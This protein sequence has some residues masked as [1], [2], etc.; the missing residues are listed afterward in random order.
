MFLDRESRYIWPDGPSV[1]NWLHDMWG[2]QEGVNDDNDDITAGV[3]TWS[4]SGVDGVQA[5]YDGI[6]PATQVGRRGVGGGSRGV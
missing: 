5:G 4:P 3:T 1:Q 6:R 2:R